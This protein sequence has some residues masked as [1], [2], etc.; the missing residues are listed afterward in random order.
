M[1]ALQ[2]DASDPNVQTH[3]IKTIKSADGI[4]IQI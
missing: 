3:Y 1:K 4:S 2:A